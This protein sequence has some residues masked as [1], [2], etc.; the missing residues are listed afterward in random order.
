V[1]IYI[2]K[3]YLNAKEELWKLKLFHHAKIYSSKNPTKETKIL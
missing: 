2:L 1:S 3:K